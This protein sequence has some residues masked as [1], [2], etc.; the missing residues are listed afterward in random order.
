MVKGIDSVYLKE[1]HR[2]P[3][4]SELLDEFETIESQRKK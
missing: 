1:N 4:V 3:I 2:D